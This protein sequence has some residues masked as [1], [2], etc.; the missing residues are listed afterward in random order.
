[1]RKTLLRVLVFGLFMA[2]ATET[3]LSASSTLT[4][5]ELAE[6]YLSSAEDAE[7][8][9]KDVQAMI[10]SL[11]GVARRSG[12]DTPLKVLDEAMKRDTRLCGEAWAKVG[13]ALMRAGSNAEK[14]CQAQSRE[15]AILIWLDFQDT[16]SV[17]KN[18]KD[19]ISKIRKR[20]T[21]AWKNYRRI[22][23]ASQPLSE[24]VSVAKEY[25]RDLREAH[26]KKGGWWHGEPL[27][28]ADQAQKMLKFA[29]QVLTEA[30][31][32]TRIDDEPLEQM[33]SYLRGFKEW[34]EPELKRYDQRAKDC[35]DK[36]V[37][38]EKPR[39]EFQ[40]A[41][42]IRGYGDLDCPSMGVG[43][44][45]EFEIAISSDGGVGGWFEDV[46]GSFR[47]N[48]VSGNVDASG[49]LN[50]KAECV[51]IKESVCYREISSCDIKGTLRIKPKL[52]GSGTLTC[53]SD[54]FI[55]RGTWQSE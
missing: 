41:G 3:S 43:W 9:A 23:Q 33:D 55:C 45:I 1:M 15:D 32:Y 49:E 29:E 21:D 6:R 13:P 50:A 38:G 24:E 11:E 51:I 26:R 42:K 18:S 10:V 36:F 22:A 31:E 14:I 44:P 4:L 40:F 25:Y 27:R 54:S 37:K 19:E 28:L 34:V 30:E 7:A 17:I 53:G 48:I 52:S 39:G 2:A 5:K 46:L 35:Y 12:G 20:L 8:E 47:Y 16:V